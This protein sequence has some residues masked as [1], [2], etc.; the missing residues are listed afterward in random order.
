[1]DPASA[2][3]VAGLEKLARL[4]KLGPRENIALIITGSGLKTLETVTEKDINFEET[5]L[6]GLERS[7]A[8][9]KRTRG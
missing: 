4:R 5:S 7:T 1:V 3:V 8:G 9:R 2:T 6:D